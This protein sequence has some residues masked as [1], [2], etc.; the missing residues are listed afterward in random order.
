MAAVCHFWNPAIFEPGEKASCRIGTLYFVDLEKRV[1]YLGTPLDAKQSLADQRLSQQV[2]ARDLIKDGGLE[3]LE[4]MRNA[5]L[6]RQ[7]SER[8]R[9][10]V[11]ESHQKYVND[12]TTGQTVAGLEKAIAR[13]KNNDPDGLVQ[14]AQKRLTGLKARDAEQAKIRSEES[15]RRQHAVEANREAYVALLHKK[16]FKN[17]IPSSSKALGLVTNFSIDCD[18]QD[19]RYLPLVNVL[20]ATAASVEKMGGELRYIIENKGEQVR[21]YAVP[22]KNGKQLMPPSLRFDI[23]EWGELRPHGITVEAIRN[24]CFGSYGP[25]WEYPKR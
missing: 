3:K 9:V 4:S 21:I 23:N 19:G 7:E 13:Y 11:E 6:A 2:T 15:K 16:Y 17:L 10:E 8:R 14:V 18:A 20:Y 5:L 1:L 25:I 12:L 24:S 22:Y